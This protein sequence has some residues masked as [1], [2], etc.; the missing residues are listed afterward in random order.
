MTQ[1]TADRSFASQAVAGE[2]K[3]GGRSGLAEHFADDDLEILFRSAVAAAH[4]GAVQPEYKFLR[5]GKRR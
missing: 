1:G 3:A 4:V 5:R 2:S